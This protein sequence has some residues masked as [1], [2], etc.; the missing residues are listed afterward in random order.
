MKRH[1]LLIIP[2]L[3]SFLIGCNTNENKDNVSSESSV[4]T[5]THQGTLEDPYTISE[6]LEII[7]KN[8]DFSKEVIYIKG[9]VKGTPYLNTKYQSWSIYLYDDVSDKSNVQVYSATIDSKA[10]YN[11]V[12]EG[13]TIIAG[14]HYVYYSSKSQPELAGSESVSYPVIYKITRGE[15]DIS[16]YESEEENDRETATETIDFTEDNHNETS[17]W[18]T[19]GKNSCYVITK[20]AVKIVNDPGSQYS[21]S[22]EGNYP[23]RFYVGTYL[24]MSVTSGKIKYVTF[25]TVPYY[26]FNEAMPI[27]DGRFEINGNITKTFAKIGAD[28]IK[29]HNSYYGQTKDVPVKQVRWT[30]L[31]VTYYK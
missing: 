5:M 29:I 4:E 27:T 17:S 9:I 31:T 20:G 15:T 12:N 26:P 24:H 16:S 25:N 1:I 28:K 13:D 10:G 7:G 8:T 2:L 19:I 22:P 18:E 11:S 21:F 14:G 30:S 6:A 23:Y 3:C